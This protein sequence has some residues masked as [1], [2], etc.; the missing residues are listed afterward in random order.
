MEDFRQGAGRLPTYP[1]TRRPPMEDR[2]LTSYCRCH[3]FWPA[4]PHR[5]ARQQTL[6]D[7]EF[8]TT[9]LV[10]MIFFGGNF[11][12]ARALL[13]TRQYIPTMLSRSRLNRRLHLLQDRFVTLLHV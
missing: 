1:C 9:V 5:E 13:G 11:A 4:L 10:A 8:M 3:D 6:T 12:H 7:V 2:I